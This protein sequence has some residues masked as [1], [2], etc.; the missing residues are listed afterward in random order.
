ML[1][2][3]NCNTTL[4]GGITA[5][6]TSMVVTSATGFPV[7]TGSQ[8]FY[9]TLADAATQTTIEIVKVTAVSGTTFTIVRGQDGTTGTIFASGAVVSLRL[10]RASLNDFPKLDEDNTFTGILT[11]YSF[12]P[13]SSTVPTN[14]LYLP[15]ANNIGWATNSTERARIDSSGNLQVGGTG[16]TSRISVY[17]SGSASMNIASLDA[18]GVNFTC[19]ANSSTNVFAG[20]ANGVDFLFNTSNIE[21]MRINSVGNVG[22][23]TS[24]PTNFGSNFRL[25]EV[26]GSDVGVIQASSSSGAVTIEMMGNTTIGYLGTR[27]NHPLALRTN[28]TERMRIYT[29]GGVSIGN[30][31]DAG[32][33][34]LSVTG[35]ASAASFIPSSSTIPTN[36]MYLPAANSLG[37]STNTT[38]RMSLD[39]NGKLTLASVTNNGYVVADATHSCLLAPSGLGGI[40]LYV[41][42]NSPLFFGTNN[43]TRMYV[44]AAGGVSIGNTVD[45]GATN[46]SVTGTIVGASTIKTGGYTVATL[47]TGVTGARAY[48][49]NALAPSFGATVVGGGAVT[50]S[51]FYNGTNWIVG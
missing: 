16:G 35:S 43:A 9:C 3:N 2:A 15:A 38:N 42:T 34:N 19:G 23:G 44:S 10:V 8:Y 18:S 12:I 7:P 40:A 28:D 49:T 41:T 31:T 29:S 24:S 32:A 4:N 36:G 11:S 27:T 39:V 30:S 22:I 25:L 46:L 20:T 14:G 48:V 6:A 13:T 45:A 47:P 5:V 26:K 17:A 21:R 51:V 33:S 50:I 1:F 37:W